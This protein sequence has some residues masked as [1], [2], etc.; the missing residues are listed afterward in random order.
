[1]RFVHP[2][3]GATW[4][5]HIRWQGVLHDAH[6]RYAEA[7]S[8][9]YRKKMQQLMHEQICPECKGERLKPYPAATLLQGKRISELTAMT[10]KEC[11]S[12]F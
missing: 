8:D 9:H 7:K 6:Q 5:D 10:V 11:A 4:V 2:E 12:F 3:T 1:M